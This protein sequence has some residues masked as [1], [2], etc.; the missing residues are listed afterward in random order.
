[1]SELASGLARHIGSAEKLATKIPRLTLHQRTASTSA[2]HVTY[3]PSIVVVAQGRKEVQIGGQTVTYDSSR[4]L[5]TSVDLPTVTRV[6]EASAAEP[7]LAA[8]LKLDVSIV[9]E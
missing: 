9:R 3:E 4:Y 8:T 5:L 2:C 7:C 6:A 1:M